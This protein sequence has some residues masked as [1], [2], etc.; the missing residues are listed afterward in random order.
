M[1]PDARAILSQSRFFMAVKGPSLDRLVAIAGVRQ[2]SAGTLIFRQQEPCPGVFVLGTGLVR[3]YKIAP[4][5]KEH[6]L[7]LVSPGGTFAEVAAIGG[8][9][10]PAF[11]E[12]L[13][14]STCALLP[15]QAFSKALREDH[16]L[17]LGLLMS[18]AGWVKHLLGITEDV[19]LRDALGRVARY[20][21]TLA[22]PGDGTVRLPSLKKHLASHLNLTSETLSRTLRRLTEMELIAAADAG[23]SADLTL[24]DREALRQLAEGE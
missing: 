23:D 7:H 13:E 17:C 19:V 21:L 12:A 16:A 15:S 3:V 8:F 24:R 22:D 20:L 11:A 18:M 4:S 10:C 14:E 2:Y 1:T 5:G 9:P 6:V